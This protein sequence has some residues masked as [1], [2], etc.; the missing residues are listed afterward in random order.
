MEMAASAVPPG[1]QGLILV[2]YWNS[3]M[4]PHWDA[5][6]SGIIAGWRGIHGPAQLYRAIL[7]GIAYELRLH[8]LG[9][10]SARTMPIDR[11]IA[12]GGGSHSG[13]WRKIIA[14]V[15][16]KPVFR[17]DAPEASA[18]GAGILAASAVGLHPSVLEAARA[19]S[20]IL[21]EAA[22]PDPVRHH[23]YSQ[24]YE[25]VYRYLYLGL[26]DPLSRLAKLVD[27]QDGLP[28]AG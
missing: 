20:R 2:P 8:G 22:Q 3:V 24:I 6:A 21:P 4:N 28:P 10:E 19:M 13:L 26:R 1:S 18:L 7:E 5:S 27:E 17:A 9:V 25:Q 15:T 23:F 16:G 14:D 11:Y 12:V